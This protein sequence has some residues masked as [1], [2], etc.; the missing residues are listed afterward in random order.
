MVTG[1]N[2]PQLEPG[3]AREGSTADLPPVPRAQCQ[4]NAVLAMQFDQRL[5]PLRERA[6]VTGRKAQALVSLSA[7]L[8]A[9]LCAVIA[10]MGIIYVGLPLVREYVLSAEWMDNNAIAAGAGFLLGLAIDL[11]LF[12]ASGAIAITSGRLFNYHYKA[13][14]REML[15]GGQALLFCDEERQRILLGKLSSITLLKLQPRPGFRQFSQQLKF[16]ASHMSSLRALQR[17]PEARLEVYAL[18]LDQQAYLAQGFIAAAAGV[19][20]LVQLCVAVLINNLAVALA[21]LFTILGPRYIASQAVLAA[22]LDYMLEQPMLQV[23]QLT[24]PESRPATAWGRYL[25]IWRG[26]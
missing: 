24:P 7:L 18:N 5:W 11:V 4:D 12:I 25:E 17:N 3:G 1:A 19:H 21:A 6:V 26:G 8:T 2:A 13:A 16:C 20:W 22:F 9:A 15:F 23:E 14:W 10:V